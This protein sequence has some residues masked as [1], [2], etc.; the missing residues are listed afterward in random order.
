MH[1]SKSHEWIRLN[2]STA[3]V[4]VSGYAQKELGEIVYIELPKVGSKVKKGEEMA[5]L[6]ST[7]AASDVYAPISGEIEAIN[8]QVKNHPELVNESPEHDGWLVKIKVSDLSELD[9]LMQETQYL[10]YTQSK[11]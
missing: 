11:S 8:D 4:G 1:Y 5:V 3:Q 7:K 10:A 2:N 9:D 6:E